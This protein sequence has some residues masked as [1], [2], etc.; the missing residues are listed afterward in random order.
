MAES[1]PLS[2]GGRGQGE[3]VSSVIC[4]KRLPAAARGERHTP[5]PPPVEGWPARATGLHGASALG[6][7]GWGQNTCRQL[8]AGIGGGQLPALAPAVSELLGTWLPDTATKV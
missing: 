8:L 2:L 1:G 3:D 5:G 7:E 6:L 4:S